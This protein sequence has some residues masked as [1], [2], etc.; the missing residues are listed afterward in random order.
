MDQ[1]SSR[2]TWER[3]SEAKQNKIRDFYIDLYKLVEFGNKANQNLFVYLYGQQMGEHLWLKFK[4]INNIFTFMNYMDI[5]NRSVI[6]SN[7][8]GYEN[9]LENNLYAHC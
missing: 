8:L 7:V 3:L 5:Q 2:L 9:N 6:L 4:E 1:T